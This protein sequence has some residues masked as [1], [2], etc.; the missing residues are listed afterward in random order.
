MPHKTNKRRTAKKINS[1]AKCAGEYY[2]SHKNE[3][4]SFAEV[5]KSP[6]FKQFYKNKMSGGD[7]LENEPTTGGG[8]SRR[9]KTARRSR[10]SRR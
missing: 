1:W 3:F 6:K 4:S 10:K 8:K 2:R 7:G 9:R 5:L